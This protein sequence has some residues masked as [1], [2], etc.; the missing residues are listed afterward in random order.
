MQGFIP[1]LSREL[2]VIGGEADPGSFFEIT[3]NLNF[4]FSKSRIRT[5]YEHC[6]IQNLCEVNLFFKIFLTID[7]IK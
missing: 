7:M 1:G 4:F 6:K 5:W 3:L 2:L